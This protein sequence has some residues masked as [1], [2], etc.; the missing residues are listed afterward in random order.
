MYKR[1]KVLNKEMNVL[2]KDIHSVG[3]GFHT[4]LGR[5]LVRKDVF[6]MDEA[7]NNWFVTNEICVA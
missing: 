1:L 5:M 3:S 6:G 4:D 2:Q 7:V